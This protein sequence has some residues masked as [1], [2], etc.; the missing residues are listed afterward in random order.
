MLMRMAAMFFGPALV[1]S[2]A[3]AGLA[4][5]HLGEVLPITQQAPT[6]MTGD[7]IREHAI[8]TFIR[9]DLDGAGAL[10]RNEYQALAVVEAE[11]ARL[12][13]YVIVTVDDGE[14]I[15]SL[16]VAASRTLS[17]AERARVSGVAL[18]RFLEAAGED[19]RLQS[20][21]FLGLFQ[22]D[23]DAFDVDQNG[24]LTGAEASALA[25]RMASLLTSA[26]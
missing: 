25:M 20:D 14:K 8:L 19:A 16:P 7:D 10:D 5:V 6:E 17:S 18:R 22:R 2:T 24:V 21:E 11:L 26:A 3:G 15:V 13:G 12:N 1:V 9:A 4:A 23:F